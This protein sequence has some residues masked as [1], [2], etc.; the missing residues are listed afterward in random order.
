MP[1]ETSDD[2]D[3]GCGQEVPPRR[4]GGLCGDRADTLVEGRLSLLEHVDLDSVSPERRVVLGDLALG[5][6]HVG[7]ERT[8]AL[9]DVVE[10]LGDAV[11]ECVHLASSARLDGGV[12]GVVVAL[13]GQPELGGDC[14]DLRLE[15]CD[16]GVGPGGALR[17][18]LQHLDLDAQLREAVL[19]VVELGS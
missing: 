11:V 4:L 5:L 15:S 19:D 6:G 18:P 3:D 1:D 16:L 9:A 7:L 13:A 10:Q 12:T 14:L 2:T 17:L 8:D